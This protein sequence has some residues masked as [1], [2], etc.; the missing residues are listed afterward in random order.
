MSAGQ[1]R[2]HPGASEGLPDEPLVDWARTARRLRLLSAVLAT[3][4]LV[5]WLA[6]SAVQGGLRPRLLGELVGLAVLAAVALEVLV[7][8]GAALR[9]LLTA[10]RRG[11]RLAAPDVSL[12]PPQVGRRR[13]R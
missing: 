2:D 5:A 13:S 4:V 12:L 9:G 8:G 7:V 3:G 10:G 1:G 11:E 6:L